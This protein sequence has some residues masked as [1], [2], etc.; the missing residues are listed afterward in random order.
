MEG[1][2][3]TATALQQIRDELQ[4][5]RGLIEKNKEEDAARKKRQYIQTIL[6]W[7]AAGIIVLLVSNFY[8]PPR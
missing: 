1:E 5:L 3:K 6:V 2:D 8:T 4:R 7:L